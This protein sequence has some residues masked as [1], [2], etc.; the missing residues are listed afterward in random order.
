MFSVRCLLCGL[1]VSAY[2]VGRGKKEAPNNLCLTNSVLCLF[3]DDRTSLVYDQKLPPV[4]MP[5]F[6]GFV[7]TEVAY[8]SRD[9]KYDTEKPYT[10]SFPVDDIAGAKVDSH[11]WVF[12]PRTIGDVRNRF[13][14]DLDVHG[15]QFI[16]WETGLSRTDFSIDE[17]VIS[18][19]Y[20]ELAEMLRKTFPRYKKLAFFDHAVSNPDV[21]FVAS[22]SVADFGYRNP[23]SQP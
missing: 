11:Q 7:H 5:D 2:I 4:S 8:F 15:F 3:C 17:I 13:I 20:S 10:T 14:P 6:T 22:I 19:Y 16:E 12:H 23:D 18:R 1:F 9:T 21:I